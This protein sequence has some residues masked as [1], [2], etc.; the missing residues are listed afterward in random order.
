MVL[1]AVGFAWSHQLAAGLGDHPLEAARAAGAKVSVLVFGGEWRRIILAPL[2]HLDILHLGVNLLLVGIMG[3]A[4][5]WLIG[6]ARTWAIFLGGA[7]LA[8]LASAVFNQS[9][10]SLGASGGGYALTGALVGL[11]AAGPFLPAG[12]P[13]RALGACSILILLQIFAGGE[14]SDKAAHLAGYALG[15]PAGVWAARRPQRWV[16][17]APAALLGVLAGLVILFA[18]WRQAGAVDALDE[19]ARWPAFNPFARPDCRWTRPPGWVSLAGES[20]ERCQTDGL[21]VLCA[22]LEPAPEVVERRLLVTALSDRSLS[23]VEASKA[24]FHCGR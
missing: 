1:L 22:R 11:L 14:T 10:F 3:S 21:V 8:T 12:R 20:G 4:S 23:T 7:W 9:A 6:H 24:T 5:T 2:H 19:P 15:L 17:R 13:R 16:S 18:E